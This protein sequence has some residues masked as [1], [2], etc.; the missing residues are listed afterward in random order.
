MSHLPRRAFIKSTLA[1]GAG[2][3]FLPS[4][5]SSLAT[6]AGTK[7][8]PVLSETDFDRN[9]IWAPEDPA[10]W[11][12]FREA[13]A[14]WRAETRQR[15][16]YQDALY[17]RPD[18]AWV[19]SSFSCCFL[20]LCDQTLYS[21][22]TNEYTLASF[23]E[24]GLK[25]FGGFDSVVLWHAYPRI[26]VDDRNQFD[27]Y[28]DSP[29]GLRGLRV[30]V[31]ESHKHGV[32]VFIAYNPWDTSTRR[33]TMSDLD[34]LAEMVRAID[35]DG[36]FLDCLGSGAPKLRAKVDAVRPGV[37]LEGEDPLALENIQDQHMSWAQEFPDS[38]APGILRNKWLERRHMQH[39]INRWTHDHTGE[40]HSAW[41]NG[42]GMM[43][44]ENVF[45]T[46]RGWSP[47]DRSILRSMLPVQRR[48][49]KL[50]SSEGWTPLVPGEAPDVFVSL[51]QD[52]VGGRRVWTLVNRS[53]R[54]VEGRLLSVPRVEGSRYFDLIKG[55]EAEASGSGAVVEIAGVI[56]PRGIA[57]FVAS[58]EDALGPDFAQFLAS[59][60]ESDSHADFRPDFPAHKTRLRIVAPMP[61]LK[62]GSIPDGMAEI[63]SGEFN[64][65]VTFRIRECGSYEPETDPAN[66]HKPLVFHRQVHL[67]EY[68]L[69][70]TPVTNAQYL[71]FLKES[72]YKPERAENFLKHWQQGAPPNDK[73]DHP[74]VY[75][76]LDDARAYARWAGKHLP[77][78][79]E[80]QYAAQGPQLRRYPW[81]N[82]MMPDCCNDGS[83]HGTT[84]VKQFPKGRSPFGCYDMCGNV[85]EWT[86]SERTDGRTRFCILKGGSYYEAKGSEWYT[87]GGVR[88]SDFALKYLL[89][90]PGLDRC[91]TIGF[92][93]AI[94][95]VEG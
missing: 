23:L 47:R 58:A 11:P 70:L 74:V 20:M 56:R 71:K 16:N 40:L 6:G 9:L 46:W 88:P 25:E 62:G 36:I 49:A 17:R 4:L 34:A 45:G 54:T 68:A 69:D 2:A 91:A 44:W 48:Y 42:S 90:W 65:A 32:K 18:F 73:E 28:R 51:W 43:V 8:Q 94:D 72:G 29:G 38:F 50:F 57:A 7:S 80:W 93:C 37:V 78:E 86:E 83:T 35:V 19:P 60:R 31:E 77:T 15:L 24:E 27:F 3:A 1:L 63:P 21:S 64:M 89:M 5:S 82:E 55:R 10:R 12:A 85:W 13:L 26:G 61:K 22:Q 66:L 52:E 92:R 95:V 81:G 84:S 87:D 41:M 59:Q 67:A 14:K 79:E 33:E 75:V 39:Q 53:E 30:L 76:D